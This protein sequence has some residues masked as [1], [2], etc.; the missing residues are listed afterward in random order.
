LLEIQV[1]PNPVADVLQVQLEEP[2][3]KTGV[4]EIYNANG[5]VVKTGVL[6]PQQTI[7]KIDLSTLTKGTYILKIPNENAFIQKKIIKQ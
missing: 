2:L 1:Y 7:A 6:T 4:M 5:Q 3:A